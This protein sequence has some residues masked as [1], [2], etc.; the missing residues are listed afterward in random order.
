M[1]LYFHNT[2]SE[3][4]W[5]AIMYWDPDGCPGAEPDGAGLWGTAGWY[6]AGP[7]G[8]AE[9]YDGDVSGLNDY[10][11][12]YAKT[13]GAAIEWT[14]NYGPVYLYHQ[15]FNSCVN[16]GSTAAY[17]VK[18]MVLIDT[19]GADDFTANLVLG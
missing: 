8:T 3:T 7:G 18:G 11:A 12:F 15:A 19:E 10:W 2:L 13:A 9:A 6:V 5:V 17:A 16:I 1:S 14:G 4:V